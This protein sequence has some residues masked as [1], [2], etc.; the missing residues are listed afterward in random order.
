MLDET[1]LRKIEAQ[2]K[3]GLSSQEI[4]DVFARSGLHLSE[5]TLRKYVQ[6][7]LLPRSVRVGEKGKHRGSKGLYP[8]R[9][10][11]QI[12][13][14]RQMMAQQY[15]IEQIQKEFLFLRGELDELEE[16]LGGIFQKLEGASRERPGGTNA[17]ILSRDVK[18]AEHM[19]RDLMGRLRTIEGRL[20]SPSTLQKVAG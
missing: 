17:S 4:L 9:V 19:G 12:L 7:G 15:T 14:I 5:A 3:K 13:V 8:V 18:E 20:R 1:T 16:A 6:L 10:V 11:R 2:G